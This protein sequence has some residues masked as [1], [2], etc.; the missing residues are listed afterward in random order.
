ML[1]WDCKFNVAEKLN[2]IFIT[3]QKKINKKV[4][5]SIN[6]L[7][8]EIFLIN[9]KYKSILISSQL[10]IFCIFENITFSFKLFNLFIILQHYYIIVE[11][12]NSNIIKLQYEEKKNT[13]NLK[14]FHHWYFINKYKIEIFINIFLY[15][16]VYYCLKYEDYWNIHS[17]KSL[18]IEI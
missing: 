7:L 15:M 13:R 1:S 12:I 16:N 8:K 17:F 3:L 9:S 4:K 10:F 11:H 6:K 18:F 2:I 5:H 14:N